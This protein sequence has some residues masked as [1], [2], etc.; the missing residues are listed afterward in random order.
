MTEADISVFP[1]ALGLTIPFELTVAILLLED[2]YFTD[3]ICLPSTEISF[4]P[5]RYITFSTPTNLGADAASACFPPLPK[6]TAIKIETVIPAILIFL[7]NLNSA[8][9]VYLLLDKRAQTPPVS[10]SV[11]EKPLQ[12]PAYPTLREIYGHI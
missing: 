6:I 3:T 11:F 4:L 2:A 10:Q 8:I 1:F 12:L 5:S 7:F 9:T